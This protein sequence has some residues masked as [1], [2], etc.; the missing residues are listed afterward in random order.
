MKR[1]L[2]IISIFLCFFL[3]RVLNAQTKN[4]Y[5]EKIYVTEFDNLNSKNINE[6]FKG[7]NGLVIEIEIEINSITKT[8]RVNTSVNNN[9]E[10]E[11][12]KKVVASLEEDGLKEL[13]AI[14]SIKGYKINKIK[15]RCTKEILNI[16]KMRSENV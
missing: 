2:I 12:L 4:D 13:A 6:V 9:L 10:K 3:V 15:I 5:V 16:I 8:Y 14:A 1:L 7:L 11:L